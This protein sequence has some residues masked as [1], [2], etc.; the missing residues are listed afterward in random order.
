MSSDADFLLAPQQSIVKSNLTCFSAMAMWAFAFPIAEVLLQGWGTIALVLV[1]QCIGVAALFAFWLWIDGWGKIVAADWRR[2]INV[3]GLGFGIGSM[4]FL[5]GQYLSDAVTPAIA[6]SMMPIIG[7]LLEVALDGRR[8]R[9]RLLL[10]ILLALAGGVLATGARIDEGNFGW[11]SLLCLASVILFAWGTRAT[12]R[13]FRALSFVGQTTITLAGSLLIV[14]AVYLALLISG[15]PGTGIG[16]FAP[17]DSAL[18]VFTS[19]ASLVLAQFLWIRG[20]SGLGI[21]LASLH[22]NAVP[23]YVMVIVVLFLDAQWNWWQAAGAGLVAS[24][25]LL[26]QSVARQP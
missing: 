15:I 24:G 10:G 3:G 17:R 18:L 6:A 25:V 13:D 21:L 12:T 11:G 7:A 14:F 16:S 20:A 22:M 26:A 2:G 8:L 4:M 5:V 23:F 9:P 19:I 1:R